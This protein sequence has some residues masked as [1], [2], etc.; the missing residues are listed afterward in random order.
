[1][2]VHIGFKYQCPACNHVAEQGCKK[3]TSIT[4]TTGWLTCPE[5]QCK[6]LVSV[7]FKRNG[8]SEKKIH[9]AHL[10]WKQSERHKDR[11][12]AQKERDG[13]VS[14]KDASAKT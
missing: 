11:I 9:I 7:M 5:C 1:M 10:D 4:P 6:H 13:R 8:E 2:A 12:H 14:T 3:P